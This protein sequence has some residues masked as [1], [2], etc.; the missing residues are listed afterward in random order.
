M[1]VVQGNWEDEDVAETWDQEEE[2]KVETAP[3]TTRPKPKTNITIKTATTDDP[4]VDE[5]EQERKARLEKLVQ[6]RDLDSAMSLFGVEKKLENLA[7]AKSNTAA[8]SAST[9]AFEMSN[10]T[11]IPEFDSFTR[12]I[13]RKLE[14]L[15]GSRHYPQFVEGLVVALMGR[16]EV[17]EIRKVVGVLSDMAANKLQREKQKVSSSTGITTSAASKPGAS[18]KNT[19]PSKGAGR[20]DECHAGDYD[21][22]FDE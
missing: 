11:S 5:T 10:P 1:A 19:K 3:R 22:P 18:L 7:A 2:T 4:I 20:F 21:D 9:P 8:A 12:L 13:T 15:E 14:S 6:E 16:R 17:P